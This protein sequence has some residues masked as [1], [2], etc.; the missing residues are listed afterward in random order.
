M[1]LDLELH[2]GSRSHVSDN[3]FIIDG[4]EGMRPLSHATHTACGQCDGDK[5]FLFS[6]GFRV[7]KVFS[8]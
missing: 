2:F 8:L 5:L 6:S 1:V 7:R 4:S 3:W